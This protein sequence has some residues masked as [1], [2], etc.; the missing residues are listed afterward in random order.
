MR[1][2]ANRI[3]TAD[4]AVDEP[5]ARL[6]QRF[7]GRLADLAGR[8]ERLDPVDPERAQRL[9]AVVGGGDVPVA[10]VGEHLPRVITRSVDL[11]RRRSST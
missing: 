7:V 6:G 3:V 4:P 1:G 8:L 11:A 2:G 10:A 9:G 5:A